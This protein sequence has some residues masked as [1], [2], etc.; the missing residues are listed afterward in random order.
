MKHLH[1]D[2]LE[3]SRSFDDEA[4]QAAA[5]EWEQALASY[6]AE[7][8]ALRPELPHGVVRLLD[9]V[10]LHDA[11][12]VGIVLSKKP[13]LSLFVRLEGTVRQGGKLLE[14]K[15]TLQDTAFRL[16]SKVPVAKK[17]LDW[18]RIQ[19][20][21]FGKVADQPAAWFSHSLLLA[22]GNELRMDFT[23]LRIRR[24]KQVLFPA[25]VQADLG[26]I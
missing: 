12:I 8:D 1:A 11:T 3:R 23:N 6:H 10:S 22:G 16:T 2:I 18:G 21:E 20:D 13:T 4:A 26:A 24:L 15:Y 7:L 9:C 17:P 5:E 19:Y 14:L 25:L